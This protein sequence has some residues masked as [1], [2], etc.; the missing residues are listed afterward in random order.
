VSAELFIQAILAFALSLTDN[1]LAYGG[2]APQPIVPTLANAV[3]ADGR[4]YA[5]WGE[6][7]LVP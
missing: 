6:F 5:F 2:W 4:T 7:A 3:D 1:L